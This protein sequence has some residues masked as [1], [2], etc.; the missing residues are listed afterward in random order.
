MFSSTI[1][2]GIPLIA[3]A[4]NIKDGRSSSSI[5]AFDQ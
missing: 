1:H 2:A 4:N 5:I 3:N